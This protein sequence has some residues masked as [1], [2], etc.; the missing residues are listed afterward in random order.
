MVAFAVEQ[1]A[2]KAHTAGS[3]EDLGNIVVVA[4]REPHI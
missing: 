3:E 4:D 2:V 1:V